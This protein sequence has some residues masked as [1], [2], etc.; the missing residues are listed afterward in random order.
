MKAVALIEGPDH[1]CYRYRIE[2]FAWAMAERGIFLESAVLAKDWLRRIGQFRAAG[3]ADVVILQ[4]R[5]L[6]VWQLALLRRYARRLIYDCDDAVFQ[7]DSYNRK[8]PESWSRTARFWAAVYAADAVIVGND[9]LRRQTVE[10][11]ERSRVHRIP[12]CVEPQL[13]R[14]VRHRRRGAEARLAWIGQRSTLGSLYR[15]RECFAAAA[16]RL[17]G[18]QMRLIC[19]RPANLYPLKVVPRQWSSATESAE[20]ADADIGVNWLPDDNWSRGKC[21]LS[22]LQ[23]M[24]AGLPV[25]ANPVGMNRRMVVHG[26]TGLLASTPQQWSEAIERL[27]ADPALRERLGR[28][29]RRLVERRY[30]VSAW[31]PK[32]ADVVASAASATGNTDSP[33]RARVRQIGI[34]PVGYRAHVGGH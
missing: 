18:L 30:S 5:L 9:H 10:Y 27:A 25:V 23:Y 28:A 24:A 21:G 26:R 29:G 15:A 1:V 20:L 32:F 2:A 34:S 19:D 11:V 22:V 16:V 6:P 13:Y 4:R 17:P 33:D 12:T 3:G 7:R 8:G 31:G 14:P